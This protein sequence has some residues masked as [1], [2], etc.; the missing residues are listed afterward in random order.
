[1]AVGQSMN[2][3]SAG[4]RLVVFDVDG[5]LY[6][7]RRL[8]R[9]MAFEVLKHLAWSRTGRRKIRI[10]QTFRRIRETLAD[11]EAEHVTARQYQD[12][13]LELKI[14]AE[15]VRAVTDEWIDRRPLPL[16]AYYA[17][18]GIVQLFK[19]LRSGGRTIAVLS[20]YPAAGKLAALDLAA[21]VIVNAVD[22][23]VDRFKPHPRGL[24]VI[25][26]ST[27]VPP[28]QTVLI[29]DRI[30]RDGLC[31]QRCG[32]RFLLKGVDA[33]GASENF[34]HYTDLAPLLIGHDDPTTHGN[35][36]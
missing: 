20:D 9:R 17:E 13:A 11:E 16:L 31:A 10:L 24:E 28:A 1:M 25:L 4:I 36:R 2:K 12:P 22:P 21:D 5:T 23:E 30:E 8:R 7:Q 26:E 19:E 32:V 34:R 27:R 15:E 14:S 3:L 33:S 35:S 29:G 18:P 6:D